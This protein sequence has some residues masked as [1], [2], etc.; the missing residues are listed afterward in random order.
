MVFSAPEEI[1]LHEDI[2]RAIQ[3]GIFPVECECQLMTKQGE[4]RQI[5]WTY[6][7]QPSPDGRVEKVIAT[8][9]DVTRERA[10]EERVQQVERKL[11]EFTEKPRPFGPM[12]PSD[13]SDRR[14]RPRRSYPYR[15]RIAFVIDGRP[16]EPQDFFEVQC[17]D[18]AAGGFSYYSANSPPSDKLIAALGAPP[19]L[20]FL[21]AKVAHTRRIVE[22]GREMYLVGCMYTGRYGA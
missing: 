1:K 10:A 20:T 7:A 21:T 8:G 16:V 18:I 13:G 11:T 5:A 19:K 15:Q 3:H 9:L 22:D 12:S 17:N 14:R 6:T 2:F 4:R